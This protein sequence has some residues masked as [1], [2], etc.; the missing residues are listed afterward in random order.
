MYP[1]LS[2]AVMDNDLALVDLAR[3]G[4][5]VQYLYLL[6]DQSG[7]SKDELATL[8]GM[9]PKTIDNYRNQ[10]KPVQN[11]Q[12]EKLLMLLRLFARGQKLF[13]E[14]KEFRDWLYYPQPALEMRPPVNLLDSIS[15]IRL[16]EECL[17]RIEHGYA[18]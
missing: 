9:A 3:K 5:D 16:V 8:L 12:A 1:S 17:D 10:Q 7:F 13:G 6:G 11:D 2:D 4:V 18:A 15:G 14:I